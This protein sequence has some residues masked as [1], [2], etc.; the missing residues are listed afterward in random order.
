[1]EY[2]RGQGPR[3]EQE[4][5]EEERSHV[6]RANKASNGATKFKR[7]EVLARKITYFRE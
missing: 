4:R 5:V 3:E 1:V 2:D 7:S 6:A